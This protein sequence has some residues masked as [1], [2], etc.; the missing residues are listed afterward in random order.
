MAK[1]SAILYMESIPLLV[2]SDLFKYNYYV[3]SSKL[4]LN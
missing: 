2:G 1:T 3:S 4:F